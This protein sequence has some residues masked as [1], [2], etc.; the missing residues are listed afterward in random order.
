MSYERY[1][2]IRARRTRD[3]VVILDIAVPRD[4]DAR[5]HDGDLTCV[6]NIDD[7][8]RIRDATLAERRKEVEP[9]EAIVTQEMQKFR[10]EWGRRRCGPVIQRLIQDADAKR[11]SILQE[12]F[13]RMNG[14]LTDADRADID[15]AFQRFQNKVLHGPISALTEEPHETPAHGHTLLEALRKL[16]RLHD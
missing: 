12:L 11:Q 13:N 5:I 7:L 2:K 14:R 10:K 3:R 16:F 4:F 8:K 6:F 15:K 9:A 1:Q